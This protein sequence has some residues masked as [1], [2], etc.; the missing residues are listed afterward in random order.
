MLHSKSLVS[1]V[2]SGQPAS[3]QISQPAGFPYSYDT[4]TSRSGEPLS[5]C[6]LKLPRWSNQRR[7]KGD[8]N[9]N[10]RAIFFFCKGH[11]LFSICVSPC[12]C[13][14]WAGQ[15]AGNCPARIL[16]HLTMRETPGITFTFTQGVEQY[17]V[18]WYTLSFYEIVDVITRGVFWG[19]FQGMAKILGNLMINGSLLRH[20][21]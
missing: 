6:L 3:P 8:Q 10:Q 17:K 16:Q 19:S 7:P 20:L 11:I 12:W 4:S 13:C 15:V 5:L 2:R 21:I 18:Q 14:C 9:P 1:R